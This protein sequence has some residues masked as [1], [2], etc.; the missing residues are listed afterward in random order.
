MDTSNSL[1][2][3]K[4]PPTD[5]ALK[6]GWAVKNWKRPSVACVSAFRNA[7]LSKGRTD[8]LVE[9]SKGREFFLATMSFLV[10]R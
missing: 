3:D 5:L 9:F 8:F 1:S 10:I 6:T 7:C 2:L 4:G